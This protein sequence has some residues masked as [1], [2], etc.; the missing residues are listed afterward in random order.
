MTQCDD[1]QTV[2][3]HALEELLKSES[4]DFVYG[5]SFGIRAPTTIV[6][7]FIDGSVAIWD[8]ERFDRKLRKSFE[9]KFKLYGDNGLG[10]IVASHSI[11]DGEVFKLIETPFFIRNIAAPEKL[12][13]IS[14]LPLARK[15]SLDD[16]KLEPLLRWNRLAQENAENA[17]VNS[18]FA[19]TRLASEPID[20]FATWLL[21]AAA[22]VGSFLVVNAEKV[23]PLLGQFG[24]LVCGLALCIS[25][26]FG[27]LSKFFGL[28][29][30]NAKLTGEAVSKSFAEQYEKHQEE[31]KK[32][33]ESAKFWGVEL[34]TDI[35]MSRV[36]SEYYKPMPRLASWVAK[37]LIEKDMNE[38]QV[39]H[40]L[41]MK[42]F[43]R[44]GLSIFLQ[45]FGL[46]FFLV[47][48]VIFATIN[49][50]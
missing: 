47:A 49:Y 13:V 11:P 41:P 12:G 17:I 14:E 27:I 29:S 38:P 42:I 45:A 24:Y 36:L 32:I 50:S 7:V 15:L 35:R 9:E 22:A 28:Q 1:L 37:K 21:V 48:G 30:K 18:M 43:F 6:H 4:P 40:I 3:L 23:L 34:E 25:C 8:F 39:A 26:F 31:E 5:I 10:L 16:P 44:Q 33:K 46:L 19:A 20:D 2:V